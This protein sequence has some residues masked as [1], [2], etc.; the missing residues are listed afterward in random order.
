MKKY[1]IRAVQLIAIF[2]LPFLLSQCKDEDEIRFELDDLQQGLNFRVERS[3]GQFDASDPASQ[4]EFTYFTEN[5]NIEKVQIMTDYYSLLN[6]ETSDR[7]LVDEVAG[8][9]LSN[10]GSAKKT[11]TLQ[12]LK[13]AI[14]ITDLAGGDQLNVF[15]I[16]H[17]TDGR[18]YPDT[19]D[20]GGVKY[21]NVESGII[22]G[23]TSS[24]TPQLSFP[25]SCPIDD[26][27][28]A[29]GSYR[30]EVIEGVNA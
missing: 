2:S 23:S 5:S 29:T 11:V 6:D 7:F 17:L 22:L 26:Q 8:S 30:F 3:A 18:V 24:F 28:F 25:I 20:A 1:Y 15:H 16:V 19:I 10:D 12:Q 21:V 13:D 27:T 9:S 14:G 4:V